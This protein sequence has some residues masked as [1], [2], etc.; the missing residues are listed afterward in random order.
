MGVHACTIIESVSSNTDESGASSRLLAESD[1]GFRD[2][3][4]SPGVAIGTAQVTDSFTCDGASGRMLPMM[5]SSAKTAPVASIFMPLSVT[6]ASS[7]F[8]TRKVGGWR[9][10]LS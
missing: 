6:P 9:S 7:S 5:T 8:V 4:V 2:H 10:L 1:S 3:S